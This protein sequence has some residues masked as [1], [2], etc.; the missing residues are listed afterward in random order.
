[1]TRL[2]VYVII[3]FSISQRILRLSL[4]CLPIT[5]FDIGV[6]DLAAPAKKPTDLFVY[7]R[8]SIAWNEI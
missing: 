5:I 2:R 1:M 4:I 6:W 3:C 7:Y 8:L